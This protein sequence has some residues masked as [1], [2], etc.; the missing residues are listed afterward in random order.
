MLFWKSNSIKI[1]VVFKPY[2]IYIYYTYL[3]RCKRFL[4]LNVDKNIAR[5]TCNINLEIDTIVL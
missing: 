1:F 3:R 5:C 4:V 2:I